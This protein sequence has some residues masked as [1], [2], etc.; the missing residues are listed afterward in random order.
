MGESCSEA[1]G[2]LAFVLWFELIMGL[3]GFARLC[4]AG[5]G[6]VEG[7]VQ[8]RFWLACRTFRGA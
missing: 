3:M 2:C 8:I 5:L 6:I 1:V 4:M 7:Y